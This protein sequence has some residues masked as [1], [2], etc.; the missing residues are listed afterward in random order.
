M[1]SL[2]SSW[3]FLPANLLWNHLFESHIYTF[4]F[5]S[6]TPDITSERL[7]AQHRSH[8]THILQLPCNHL[9]STFSPSCHVYMTDPPSFIQVVS[10]TW[11]CGEVSIALLV[12]VA[13]WLQIVTPWLKTG[14]LL[15][16]WETVLLPGIAYDHILYSDI[17]QLCHQTDLMHAHFLTQR[18][19][20]DVFLAW[21]T[22]QQ[23]ICK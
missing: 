2:N 3:G 11:E 6:N 12:I 21:H 5:K 9:K 10:F 4:S 14:P 17:C 19:H 20:S 13:Q 7:G 22:V 1:P 23:V 16:Q 8:L 18:K 15:L